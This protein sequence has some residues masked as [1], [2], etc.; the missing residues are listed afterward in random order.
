[1]SPPPRPR[2]WF[3]PQ[4]SLRTLLV[5]MSLVGVGLTVYRWPWEEQSQHQIGKNGDIADYVRTANYRR[6]WRGP[7]VKH[8]LE[9]ITRNKK[10]T[11]E[12]RYEEGLLQ[13]PRRV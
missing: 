11:L 7:P 9:R 13:G 8:G 5:L 10:V 2:R 4:I 12:A 1:M 3:R 6:S